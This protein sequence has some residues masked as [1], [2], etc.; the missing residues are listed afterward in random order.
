MKRD[1]DT[2]SLNGMSGIP[3]LD[4]TGE[5]SEVAD[6]A[7][8]DGKGRGEERDALPFGGKPTRGSSLRIVSG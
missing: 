2:F 8:A 4:L 1:N 7:M 5:E 6:L 3:G